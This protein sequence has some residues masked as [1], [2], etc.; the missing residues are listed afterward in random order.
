MALSKVRSLV[1]V[2]M[3]AVLSACAGSPIKV[4]Q[5]VEQKAYATYGTFVIFEEQAVKLTA[6]SSNLAPSTKAQIIAGVQK[7]QPAVDT[8]LKALN[9]AEAAKADFDAQKI[10][11]TKFQIVVDSL[12]SWVQQ[13]TPLVASLVSVVRGAH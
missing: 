11:K 1:L 9:Q 8:M 10:D 6:P 2:A 13:A 5:T 12:G 3:V 4:A 7:A